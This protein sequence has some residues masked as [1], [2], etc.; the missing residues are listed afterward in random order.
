MAMPTSHRAPI[1]MARDG[2][3]GSYLCLVTRERFDTAQYIS[4]DE[5]ASVVP[6]EK[7]I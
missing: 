7:R 2:R 6:S 1:T 3:Q 5:T 4:V